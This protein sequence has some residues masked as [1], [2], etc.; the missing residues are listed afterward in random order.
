MYPA[1]VNKMF[2]LQRGR[3]IQ[4]TAMLNW[5]AYRNHT[6]IKITLRKDRDSRIYLLGY[7]RNIACTAAT[8]PRNPFRMGRIRKYRGRQKKIWTRPKQNSLN[9]TQARIGKKDHS[10]PVRKSGE[11]DIWSEWQFDWQSEWQSKSQL[12]DGMTIDRA[13]MTIWKRKWQVRRATGFSSNKLN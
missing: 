4:E 3:R 10:G 1:F 5:V 6:W 8:K 12:N 7:L 11:D 9:E 2:P 13:M